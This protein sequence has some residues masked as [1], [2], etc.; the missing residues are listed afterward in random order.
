VK[1]AQHVIFDEAMQDLD[2]PPPNARL[3]GLHLPAIDNTINFLNLD[4]LFPDIDIM[5]TP[6][7]NIDT[8]PIQ[9][10]FDDLDHPLGFLYQQC[11]RLF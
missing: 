11:S 6:F 7:T 8:F 5:E 3:L 2:H 10:D 4:E 9:L 1:S